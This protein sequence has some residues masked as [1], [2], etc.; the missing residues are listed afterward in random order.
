MTVTRI[1]QLSFLSA[2]L[3]TVLS[4]GCMVGPDYRVPETQ[5]N[6][7]WIEESGQAVKRDT[8]IDAAWWKVFDD[9]VL[10]R[11]VE[12]AYRNNLDLR[13]AGVRVLQAMAQRNVTWGNLWPQSQIIGGAFSRNRAS[14]NF[15]AEGFPPAPESYWNS[16][17]TGFDASWEL[18]FWGKIRRSIEAADAELDAFIASYDNVMVSL[19]AEV[20]ATYVLIRAAEE[21]T[22]GS[23]ALLMA[24]IVPYFFG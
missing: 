24:I 16:W 14:D 7:A 11:L 3:S 2:V 10:V 9:P 21:Q 1:K 5:V 22:S 17:L 12:D 13:V 18:D 15:A 20:A 6:D 8:A 23:S 19:I 4:S